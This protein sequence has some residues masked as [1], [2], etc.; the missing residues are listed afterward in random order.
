MFRKIIASAL[1]AFALGL[2]G[3][4]LS[5]AEASGPRETPNGLCGAANM[6]NQAAAPHMMEAMTLHT[7]AQGNAGMYTAVAASACSN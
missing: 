2:V 3:L 7:A 6:V 1:G 4:G 5:S